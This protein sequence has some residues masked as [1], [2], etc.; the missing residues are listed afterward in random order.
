MVNAQIKYVTSILLSNKNEPTIDS[1]KIWRHFKR[2]MIS[3]R[4]QT[5]NDMYYIPF[6]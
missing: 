3:E 5:Q 2:I 1:C 4:N 6:I